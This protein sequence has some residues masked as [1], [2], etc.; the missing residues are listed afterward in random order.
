MLEYAVFFTDIALSAFYAAILYVIIIRRM[1]PHLSPNDRKIAFY[2]WLLRVIGGVSIYHFYRL[3]YGGGDVINFISDSLSLYSSLFHAPGTT[4]EYFFHSVIYHDFVDFHLKRPEFAYL[5]YSYRIGIT[6]MNDP[7]TA[8]VPV[9]YMPFVIL[10]M[11]FIHPSIVL[12]ATLSFLVFFRFYQS[13]K[14]IYPEAGY[15]LAFP[16][17]FSPSVITWISLPFKEAVVLIMLLYTL[18]KLIFYPK[19]VWG[20]IAGIPTFYLTSI[21]KPYVIMSITPSIALS[22]V[23]RYVDKA[24]RNVVYYTFYWFFLVVGLIVSAYGIIYVSESQSKYS[25][26]NILNYAQVVQY[27]L[28]R[29]EVYYG[30]TGGSRYD[31]GEFSPTLLGVL[32]K[33]PIAFFTGAFRPLLWESWKFVIFISSLEGTIFLIYILLRMTKYGLLKLFIKIF[34]SPFGW[35]FIIYSITFLFMTGLTSGNFGNLVRYRMPGLIFFYT[36]IIGTYEAMAAEARHH[37][38]RQ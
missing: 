35:P 21:I 15:Y 28:T 29:N 26:D 5:W 10:S 11:G 4:I 13:L 18:E 8:T 30:E 34:N 36:I 33:F 37:R 19:S 32:Q 27:D 24:K 2:G 1:Y 6:Y 22:Y 17:I 38:S 14:N 31:I 3:Y 16:F 20:Y 12:F 9:L 23:T 25:L 7:A